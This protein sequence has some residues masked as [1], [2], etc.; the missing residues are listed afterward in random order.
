MVPKLPVLLAS[1]LGGLSLASA[2]PQSAQLDKRSGF[3]D[4]QPIDDQ[5]RGGPLLGMCFHSR[6]AN[7]LHLETA[8]R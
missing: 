3:D 2:V 7:K 4:G 1:L 5:G 6:E 8:V